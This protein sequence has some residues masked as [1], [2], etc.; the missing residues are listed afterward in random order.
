VTAVV[1]YYVTAQNNFRCKW[2]TYTFYS[3]IQRSSHTTPLNSIYSNVSDILMEGHVGSKLSKFWCTGCLQST[4][5]I[6]CYTHTRLTALCPGLHR[7]AGTRKEK[8][9]WILLKQETASGSGI[10]RAICKSVPWSKQITTPA[11]HRSVFYRPDALPATQP[12][13]STE[14]ML[15]RNKTINK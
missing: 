13:Q 8:L 11:P 10:S 5:F 14:G 2:H 1:T 12:C 15:L 9:I 3:M 4:K 6:S 7:W